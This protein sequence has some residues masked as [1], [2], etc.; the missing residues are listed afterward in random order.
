MDA[1]DNKPDVETEAAPEGEP[2]SA[3]AGAQDQTDGTAQAA[4]PGAIPSEEHESYAGDSGSGPA[5]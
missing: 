5:V 1:A 4:D 2:T 3:S